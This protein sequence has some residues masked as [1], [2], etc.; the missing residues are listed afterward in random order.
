MRMPFDQKR[1]NGPE[2]S[3]S[4][5]QFVEKAEDSKK[6]TNK[7]K[8]ADGRKMSEHRQFGEILYKS[9]ID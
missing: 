5:K 3:F 6:P 1:I 9:A 7:V 2:T 8:R 4:Y